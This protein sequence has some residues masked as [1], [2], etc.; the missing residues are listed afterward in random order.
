MI[1]DVLGFSKKSAAS[2]R[3]DL[4]SFVKTHS[5][6][7]LPVIDFYRGKVIKSLG[8]SFLC[9]FESATDAAVCAIAIQT[10]ILEFNRKRISSD[11]EM[12]IRVVINS[13]DVSIVNGDIFG[14]A[15]NLAARMEKMEEI[16]DGGI[17]ISQSTYLLMNRQEVAA[18]S[19]GPQTF[20]GISHPVEVYKLPLDKQKLSVLPT[21]FLDI[22]E[23]IAE[24]KEIE[25]IIG[26]AIGQDKKDKT[27]ASRDSKEAKSDPIIKY[28]I[29][30]A[31]LL[32]L[33][34]ISWKILFTQPAQDKNKLGNS[35]LNW[36]MASD[37][38]HSGIIDETDWIG[39]KE[40]FQKIDTDK[41]HQLTPD[42]I[43]KWSEDA[44]VELPPPPRN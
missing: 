20:K 37:K 17:A 36:I 25:S 13:G 21:R 12:K 35:V 8:D 22:V 38:K 2:T 16:A 43:I 41:N 7:L 28:S 39:P 1:T 10:I 5:K 32:I 9:V 11:L 31:V 26:Q 27:D 19:L 42:E 40:V 30:L 33:I 18:D 29:V 34:L 24:G 6:L 15:V 14:D 3:A 23:R 44:G 4:I